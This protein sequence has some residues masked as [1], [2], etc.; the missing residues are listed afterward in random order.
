MKK[1]LFM[2]VFVPVIAMAQEKVVEKTI[3]K[4]KKERTLS[5]MD[6]VSDINSFG[7]SYESNAG[8]HWIFKNLKSTDILNVF[9]TYGVLTNGF[10]DIPGNGWGV[11]VGTRTYLKKEVT[12]GFYYQNSFNYSNLRFNA[13][14]VD[15]TYSYVSLINP[16]FGYKVKIAKVVNFELNAGFMWRWEMLKGQG[17]LDNKMFDNLVPKL[18]VKLG[19]IF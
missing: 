2:L 14:G 10:I 8:K 5:V 18:G 9:L 1:L 19:W 15:G 17:N 12:K 11:E 13:N 16:D 3:E 7:L 6:V 4:V